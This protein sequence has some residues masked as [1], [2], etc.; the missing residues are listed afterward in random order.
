MAANQ[1]FNQAV[2][3]LYESALD[4]ACWL[5]AFAA[6][7]KLC[8]LKG[9]Q[10]TVTGSDADGNDDLLFAFGYRY[11]EDV[12]EIVDDWVENYSDKSENIHGCK[13]SLWTC[14][15]TTSSSSQTKRKGARRCTTSSSQDTT[16][17]TRWG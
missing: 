1:T 16:A 7:D 4:D 2:T 15:C 3:L 5:E 12:Q 8:G 11:G 6:I 9:G 14:C 13:R 17:A 10:L